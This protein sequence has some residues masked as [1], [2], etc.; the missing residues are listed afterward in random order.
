MR[1]EAAKASPAHPSP[2][3]DDTRFP[4]MEHLKRTHLLMHILS[5][6][7]L[8]ETVNYLKIQGFAAGCIAR[9]L[10]RR[11]FQPGFNPDPFHPN[12][13]IGLL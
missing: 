9:A 12:S 3:P 13:Q 7:G 6:P 10:L 11:P 8:L 5:N 4:G 1:I 2:P